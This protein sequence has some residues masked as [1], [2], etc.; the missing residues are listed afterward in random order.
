MKSSM[1]QVVGEEED[2]VRLLCLD[3]CYFSVD[4]VLQAA[5]VS[6]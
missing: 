2:I 3:G 5:R 1:L 6:G 4:Y